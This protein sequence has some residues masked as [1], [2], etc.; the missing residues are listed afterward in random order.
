LKSSNLS[1]AEIICKRAELLDGINLDVEKVKE[2]RT[3]AVFLRRCACTSLTFA[4][5]QF[6]IVPEKAEMPEITIKVLSADV[7]INAH[8]AALYERA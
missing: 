5:I 1:F 6:A 7:V 2:A 3:S 8:D 4:V